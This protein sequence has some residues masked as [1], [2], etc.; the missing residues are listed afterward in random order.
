MTIANMTIAAGLASVIIVAS[1]CGGDADGPRSFLAHDS[2]SAVSVQ[3]TRVGADVSGSLS[4]ASITDS[5]NVTFGEKPGVLEVESKTFTGTVNDHSVRLQ[6]GGAGAFGTRINGRLDGDTLEL[7]FPQA[8]G[9]VETVKLDQSSSGEYTKVVSQIRE[10]IA[11]EDRATKRAVT[12]VA[13]AYQKA[14][15]PQSPDD[16]CRY[17]TADAVRSV[18]ASSGSSDCAKALRDDDQEG[19]FSVGDEPLGIAKIEMNVDAEAV[20]YADV[21][22]RGG[23]QTYF[24]KHNGRW[25]VSAP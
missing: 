12:P 20:P 21:T 13:I 11:R 6:V 9:G 16:P 2:T 18:L 15:D 17:L 10:R 22:W 3:W 24:V 23:L 8:E 7:T 19:P 25:L 1:A 5:S 4:V 14:L